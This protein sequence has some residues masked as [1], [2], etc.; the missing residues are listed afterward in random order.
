MADFYATPG[1]A[2]LMNGLTPANAFD[3]FNM[4]GWVMGAANAGD[5]LYCD[6]GNYTMFA[7]ATARDGTAALRISIIGVTDL[8]NPTTTEATGAARPEWDFVVNDE[9]ALDNL[10]YA[11]NLIFTGN[12]P[13]AL[14]RVDISCVVTNCEVVNVGNGPGIELNGSYSEAINCNAQSTGGAAIR[15]TSSH[16]R[17]IDCDI[18]DSVIGISITWI[19]FISN[20]LIRDCTT[21]IRID[22][23]RDRVVIANNTLYSGTTGIEAVGTTGECLFI[24]NIISDF[25]TPAVWVAPQNSDVWDY[26]CWFNSDTPVNV[27]KGPNAI[28]EDPQFETP[29]TDFRV[30]NANLRD[31]GLTEFVIGA[32]VQDPNGFAAGYAAGLIDG[33][34]IGYALGYAAGFAD[35]VASVVCPGVPGTGTPLDLSADIFLQ[36]ALETMS[37]DGVDVFP[38]YRLQETKDEREPTE[39]VYLERNVRF[40]FPVGA[41]IYAGLP[42]A[43]H[44]DVG[45]VI[46]D[47]ADRA[48]KIIGIQ[49]PYIPDP[50]NPD[51]GTVWGVTTRGLVISGT[52]DLDSTVSLFPAVETL[53]A[54][55]STITTHLVVDGAFENVP[56]AIKL[57]GGDSADWAGKRQITEVYDIYVDGDIGQVNEGDV[58]KDQDDKVYSIVSYRNRDEI[59]ELSA[60]EC[61]LRNP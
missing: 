29:G 1:G 56:A 57:R 8:N 16:S 46:I 21:A 12:T 43:T 53:S 31:V 30:N 19:V 18:H 45:G 4:A 60:I 25:T 2:G 11:R 37:L 36:D 42:S 44:P 7:I 28:N 26:N 35:G 5:K 38:V 61:E 15:V 22:N 52:Y 27:T 32:I 34:V 47:S 39:G 50:T 20:N 48:Y 58:L 6:S 24:G 40:H 54:A 55:G 23:A 51:T 17:V 14:L 9:M 3:E 49:E 13:V 41:A 10:W 59:G 33:E